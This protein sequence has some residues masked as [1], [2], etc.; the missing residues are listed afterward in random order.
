MDYSD[1]MQKHMKKRK[2]LWLGLMIIT[3]L[4]A[5]TG[6][7]WYRHASYQAPIVTHRKPPMHRSSTP[8]S[9]Y[10]S[11]GKI[12]TTGLTVGATFYGALASPENGHYGLSNLLQG[13]TKN[14]GQ[15][16]GYDDNGEGACDGKYTRL[17]GNFATWAEDDNGTI[18][19]NLPCGTKLEI[20]YH[21][22]TIV[23]EK[24]D[25][26]NGGCTAPATRCSENGHER[27]IDLWWQTAKALCFSEQPD[28]MTIHVVPSNTPTTVIPNYNANTAESTAVCQ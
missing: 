19:G 1:T 21:G 15:Y 14:G 26:S 2:I 11:L 20:Q 23:A 10:I 17:D 9:G 8:D 27:A 16:D 24:G 22:H 18:L 13:G 28:V 25:T 4:L 3:I 7:L 5:T 12:P 6:Y